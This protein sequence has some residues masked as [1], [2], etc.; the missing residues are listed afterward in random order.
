MRKVYVALLACLLVGCKVQEPE[1][2]VTTTT[3]TTTTTASAE[4]EEVICVLY[5]YDDG[6]QDVSEDDVASLKS[7]IDASIEVSLNDDFTMEDASVPLYKVTFE[8]AYEVYPFDE[9]FVLFRNINDGKYY[10]ART[11]D[12]AKN[13]IAI[14][15]NKI[16]AR[17][18][19]YPTGKVQNMNSTYAEDVLEKVNNSNLFDDFKSIELNDGQYKASNIGNFEV[20]VVDGKL[21]INSLHNSGVYILKGLSDIAYVSPYF[22]CGGG[23]YANVVTNN[24]EVYSLHIYDDYNMDTA[25]PKEDLKA[26]LDKVTFNFDWK[27]LKVIDNSTP[28]TTCGFPVA[29]VLTK[30]NKWHRVNDDGTI[31]A[32]EEEAHPYT[33]YLNIDFDLHGRVGTVFYVY[34]DGTVHLG[35]FHYDEETENF[36]DALCDE[37]GNPIT[38]ISSYVGFSM[39]KAEDHYEHSY[40]FFDDD[41]QAYEY[42]H[43]VNGEIPTHAKKLGKSKGHAYEEGADGLYIVNVILEDGT[44]K[45]Y[46]GYYMFSRSLDEEN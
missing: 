23:S 22:T 37:L 42:Y 3:T 4:T 16:K 9:T 12:D 45:D 5:N 14:L 43:E 29:Y 18:W 21:Y 27:E 1:S 38:N 40:I 11:T 6:C 34:K 35:T 26:S 33:D 25:L 41:W 7:I 28:F 36:G 10:A 2:T 46:K 30:D 19:L 39:S 15:P 31:G 17:A 13:W 24:H 44:T 20:S 8:D 32:T